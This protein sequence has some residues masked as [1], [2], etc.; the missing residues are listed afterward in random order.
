MASDLLAVKHLKKYFPVQKNM[1]FGK[2]AFIHAVDGISFAIGPRQTIGLV[3]ESGCGKTTLGRTLVNLEKPTAGEIYFKGKNTADFKYSEWYEYRK[4]V[5]FIFQD[6]Y[7]SLNPRKTVLDIVTTSLR[8]SNLLYSKKKLAGRTEELL[9]L[10]GLSTQYCHHYPHEFSGG[11]RQRISI[12]RALALSPELLICDEPVSAL[13]VSIQAQ[14]LNLLNGLKNKFNLSLIFISHDLAVVKH[15]SDMIFVMYRGKIVEKAPGA[16]LFAHTGHPY[17][18]ALISAIPEPKVGKSKERIILKGDVST[19]V[20]EMK[21]CCF[22]DRCYMAQKIC[23]KQE[24]PAKQV[25]KEH[26]AF[27]HFA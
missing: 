23:K 4:S 7:S 22:Q 24:P 3:G 27:C 14:V 1:F 21:G 9:K 8:S 10:V 13:D 12:A 6:P 19:P 16:S 20:G 15:V 26:T 11:Q 18:K 25:A 5:Q 17:S 2:K